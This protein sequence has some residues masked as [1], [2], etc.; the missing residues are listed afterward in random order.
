[1]EKIK[2]GWMLIV[3]FILI[4][5]FTAGIL[6][7][8]T[9]SLFSNVAVDNYSI[10]LI[11]LLLLLPLISRIKKIKLGDFEV[12]LKIS[13][14]EVVKGLLERGIKIDKEDINKIYASSTNSNLAIATVDIIASKSI[15][16]E[17][18]KEIK[19]IPLDEEAKTMIKSKTL[20]TEPHEYKC[21]NCGKKTLR[22]TYL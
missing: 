11:G 16:S 3:Y 13:K 9:F 22:Y 12:E 20:A 17:C 15:C 21:D 1:M 5:L 8:H 14:G 7:T 10:L 4:G 2:L 18:G 19:E 6:I